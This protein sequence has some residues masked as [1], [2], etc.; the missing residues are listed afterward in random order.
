MDTSGNPAFGKSVLENIT[1]TK[2]ATMTVGGTYAKTFLLLLIVVISGFVTWK[3]TNASILTDGVH[4]FPLWGASLLTFF[5]AMIVSFKPKLAPV[6][7]IPYAIVQGGLLGIVSGMFA[8]VY[9]GIVGQAV[10]ATFAVFLAV[11]VGYSL[12]FLRASSRFVKVILSAMIGI[13]F[14]SLFSWLLSLFS[15]STP[16]IYSA[17]PWGIA[18]SVFVVIIAALSLVIDFDFIDQA[19]RNKYPKY[20][21][22]YGAFG[23]MVGLIWLYMEV[24]RL[25]AKIAANNRN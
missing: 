17:S 20:F 24:L 14:F 18:F 10:F 6:L 19:A 7:S 5:I 13:L 8:Q 16:V 4:W 12:G 1:K 2:G 23:L 11:L 3:W 21:E 9:D 25:L 22:W 15:I